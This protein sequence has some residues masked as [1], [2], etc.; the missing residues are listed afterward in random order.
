VLNGTALPSKQD[1]IISAAQLGQLSYQVGNGSDTL[2]VKANDG[3]TWG[4]WSK[5]FTISDQISFVCT[6]QPPL[7]VPRQYHGI[8]V[9]F[10]RRFPPIP[11]LPKGIHYVTGR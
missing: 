3:T 9:M 6:R 2:W 1:T 11:I 5:S 4:N 7:A 8:E 10:P